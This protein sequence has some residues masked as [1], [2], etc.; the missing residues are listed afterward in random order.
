MMAQSRI[1]DSWKSR[2]GI[3]PFR[4]LGP[5]VGAMMLLKKVIRE[6][7]IIEHKMPLLKAF[8]KLVLGCAE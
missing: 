3:I 2:E 1:C 6:V 4:G 7:T 8:A 5:R